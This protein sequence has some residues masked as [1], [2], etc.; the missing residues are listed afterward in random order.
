MNIVEST[1]VVESAIQSALQK[2]PEQAKA[3][4]WVDNKPWGVAVKKAIVEVGENFYWLTAARDVPTWE[5]H[6]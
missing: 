6:E 2:I 4:V 1:D 3:E 5:G